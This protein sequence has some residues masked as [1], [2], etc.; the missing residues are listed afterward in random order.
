MFNPNNQ[1]K[2]NFFHN[3]LQLLWNITLNQLHDVKTQ[4]NPSAEC[5]FEEL[6]RTWDWIWV[7]L[8]LNIMYCLC[9]GEGIFSS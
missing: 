3:W 8:I 6:L 7:R 2:P 5:W 4:K 1:A 9:E